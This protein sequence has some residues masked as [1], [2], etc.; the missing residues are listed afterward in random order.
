MSKDRHTTDR[1]T[2]LASRRIDRRNL[3][4]AGAAGIAAASLARQAGAQDTSPAA[5]PASAL[6]TYDGSEVTITYGIWDA[7]QEDGVR[8]QIEAFN[9][10][11]PNITVELQLT[12]WSDYWTKLQT[13]VA[14]GQA[15]DVFWLNSANCPVYASAGALVP[16]QELFDNGSLDAANYPETVLEL[17]NWQGVQYATPREYDTIGLFYNKDIFDEAGE[18]YPDDTWDWAKLREMAE[19][20]KDDSSGRW[21]LGLQTGGQENYTNF[22]FQ[23][24]GQLLNEDRTACVVAD[25]ENTAEAI[26]TDVQFFVDEL[27]PGVDIQQSNPV[28]ESLFPAGQVAM[29]PGGSF[30]AKTYFDADANIDVA[31][32]PKGKIRATVIH[33]LGNVVWSGSKNQGAAVEFARFLAT[34]P[35]ERILGE[36]G[37]GIPA[38]K[39]LED[40]WLGSMPEFNAQVFVDASEY[41][42]ITPDPEVGPE[43]QGRLGE[44]MLKGFSGETPVDEVPQAAQDSANEVL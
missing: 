44:E 16:L 18:T 33:G 10:E 31:P 28:A 38:Y 1:V 12:P 40:T 35:A 23:N 37:M 41:G 3:F 14:G 11:F 29:M 9:E 15:F 19:K 21:G 36:S 39:G 8:Q 30:R 6:P 34:E 7:A 5:S 43:W 27:T 13:S 4:R 20:M 2:P 24:E 17:Y 22:I 32:L 26:R 25:D 42:V